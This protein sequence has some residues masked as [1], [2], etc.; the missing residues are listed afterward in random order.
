MILQALIFCIGASLSFAV[1]L[2]LLNGVNALVLSSC[3]V[4]IILNH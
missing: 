3:K 1:P 2:T 4:K